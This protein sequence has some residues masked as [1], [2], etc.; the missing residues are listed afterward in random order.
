[1]NFKYIIFFGF[2]HLFNHFFFLFLLFLFRFRH[3]LFIHHWFWRFLLHNNHRF[4]FFNNLFCL[5]FCFYFF[6]CNY[7]SFSYFLFNLY[8]LFRNNR[9]RLR[10]F[11]WFLFGNRLRS[12]F[13]R[14]NCRF[15]LFYN[16][17]FCRRCSLCCMCLFIQILQINFPN[18]FEFRNDI[19]RNSNF[20]NFFLSFL[21]RLFLLL[22]FKSIN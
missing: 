14:C 5:L 7:R 3:I 18:W 10:H 15:W 9:T 2:F 17:F 20:Y 12:Y 13:L 22:L 11:S 6:L 16:L 19:L 21:S 8:L 1:M 4:F